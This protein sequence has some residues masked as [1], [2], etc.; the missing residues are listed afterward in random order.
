VTLSVICPTRNREPI[1]RQAW[2]TDSLCRQTSLPDELVIAIDHTEDATIDAIRC[3]K[4]PFPVKILDIVAPRPGPL[5]ASGTPDNCLIHAATGDVI[6]HVDDDLSLPP[7]C[8]AHTR[9]LFDGLPPAAIWYFMTFVNADG[10]E[11][12]DGQDWRIELARAKAWQTL[13][14]NILRSPP[15]SGCSTGA[16]FAVPRAVLRAIGGHDL[17]DCGFHNQDTKLGFRLDR[18][19]KAG[20]YLSASPNTTALHIGYTWHMQHR[21]DQAAIRAAYGSQHPGRP[22]ANGGQAF[23]NSDWFK[24]SYHDVT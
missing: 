2:L 19:C 14:G 18:Y 22:I 15:F 6:L 4:Y 9:H 5:P 24:D 12:L 7:G 17:A 8:I 10:T 11:L 1:W 3:R 13:P 23:W 20:S 16:I 21:K